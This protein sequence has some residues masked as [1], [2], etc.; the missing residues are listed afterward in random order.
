MLTSSSVQELVQAELARFKDATLKRRMLDGLVEPY[1]QLRPWNYGEP[2]EELPCWIVYDA[3]GDFVGIAYCDAGFGP[4]APWGLLW[5]EN[6]RRD[7]G[8]DSGWFAYLEQAVLE[9]L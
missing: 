2:G 9:K 6:G 4:R 7:M 5:L 3:P 1:C 8:D